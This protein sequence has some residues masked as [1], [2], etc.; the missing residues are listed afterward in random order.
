MGWGAAYALTDE[1]IREKLAQE[2]SQED[3]RSFG[4]YLLLI[5][6]EMRELIERVP[7]IANGG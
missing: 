2:V 6:A 1:E 4:E 7:T 3:A 5:R